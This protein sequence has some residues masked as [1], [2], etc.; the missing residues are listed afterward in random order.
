ME[1]KW[2]N[3]GKLDQSATHDMRSKL[4]KKLNSQKKDI[5][6]KTEVK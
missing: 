4:K 3:P 1:K 2:V 5:I 6:K